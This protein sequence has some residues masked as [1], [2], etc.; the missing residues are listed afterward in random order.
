MNPRSPLF[1]LVGTPLRRYRTMSFIAG[2]ALIVLFFVAIPLSA[3]HH[4]ALGKY[5][6]VAHGVI[7]FP[8]YLATIVQLAFTTRLRWYWWIV[9]VAGGLLPI[10]AFV[11][12]HFVTREIRRRVRE[13]ASTSTRG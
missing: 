11:A 1:K 7:I 5:L 4:P 6:G 12:E 13:A 3:S 9:M 2:I 10:I 8:L